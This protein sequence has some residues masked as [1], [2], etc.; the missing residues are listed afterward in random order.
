MQ[1]TTNEPNVWFDIWSGYCAFHL[2]D[3]KRALEIYES[4]QDAK[5]ENKAALTDL[6]IN[7]AVCYFYLGK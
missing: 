6:D 5:V 3:Y 4:L 1:N 7:R 2:G